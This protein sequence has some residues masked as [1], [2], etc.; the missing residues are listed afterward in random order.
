[1]KK[2]IVSIIA[3][4]AGFSACGQEIVSN[5]SL[6]ILTTAGFEYSYEQRLGG[7][8]SLIGRLGIESWSTTFE[9]TP[10]SLDFNTTMNPTIAIEPRFYT[11][12]N[13]RAALG[14]NT[15]YNSSDFVAM[16]I[17]AIFGDYYVALA[18]QYGIRRTWGKHWFCEGSFGVEILS[19]FESLCASPSARFRLGF[20]F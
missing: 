7:R 17:Q 8:F 14:R 9:K 11:S 6:S 13:R 2:I 18:P 3:L 1:M 12:I 10:A 4:L 5:H 16:P 20:K 19:D 15:S